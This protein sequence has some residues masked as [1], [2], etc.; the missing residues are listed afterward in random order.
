[1]AKAKGPKVLTAAEKRKKTHAVCDAVAFALGI[2]EG[3]DNCPENS[4]SENLKAAILASN[5][6]NEQA[7]MTLAYEKATKEKA[8]ELAEAKRQATAEYNARQVVVDER[9][10]LQ[11][12]LAESERLRREAS[13]RAT[14]LLG[15]VEEQQEANNA[16]KAQIPAA[17]VERTG[18]TIVYL[19][20]NKATGEIYDATFEKT[21]VLHYQLNNATRTLAP[22]VV[23]MEDAILSQALKTTRGYL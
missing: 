20:K 8:D 5:T 3:W 18:D 4:A 9:N 23:N 7:I 2:E 19:V 13:A 11:D 14:T 21:T 15:L 16:L 12:Q 22:V 10:T 6:V 17:K 1:M